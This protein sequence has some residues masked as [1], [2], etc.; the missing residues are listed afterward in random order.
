MAAPMSATGTTSAT[1]LH[2]SQDSNSWRGVSVIR[3]LDRVRIRFLPTRAT[4]VCH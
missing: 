2:H 1:V 3:I 4:G